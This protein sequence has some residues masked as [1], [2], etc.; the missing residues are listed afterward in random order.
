M[1]HPANNNGDNRTS[2]PP[3]KYDSIV[4]TA[5]GYASRTIFKSF[6]VNQTP[7][8]YAVRTL[9][10]WASNSLCFG[11]SDYAV[12]KCVKGKCDITTE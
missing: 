6:P 7:K 2:Q 5:V 11:H 10:G 12:C 3:K 1:I 9:L 4:K 8:R